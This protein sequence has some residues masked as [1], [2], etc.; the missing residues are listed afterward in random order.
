M[1]V[2]S[3]A[4]F[5]DISMLT[6]QNLAVKRIAKKLTPR[7]CCPLPGDR[8]GRPAAPVVSFRFGVYRKA[9][10]IQRPAT[11][12]SCT[13]TALPNWRMVWDHEPGS[14]KVSGNP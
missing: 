1:P 4:Q 11:V 3:T 10:A 8:G 13:G 12:A 14:S 7:R 5:A 2:G 6:R 9:D